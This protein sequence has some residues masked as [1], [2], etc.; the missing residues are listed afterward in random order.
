[1]LNVVKDPPEI[2]DY[3]LISGNLIKKF[4][5]F[6]LVNIS[7]VEIEHNTFAVKLNDVLVSM[8]YGPAS[9]GLCSAM[10][11]HCSAQGHI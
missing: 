11:M 8:I 9:T 1:M 4:L 3:K 6:R 10:I 7:L 2:F 5:E